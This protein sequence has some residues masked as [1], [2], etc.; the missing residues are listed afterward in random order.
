MFSYRLMRNAASSLYRNRAGGA[1]P[2]LCSYLV[3]S[4]CNL[5]C[6]GCSYRQSYLECGQRMDGRGD[7]DTNAALALLRDSGFSRMPALILA[8]GE[9]LM[10]ED[11]FVL[12]REA[13]SH[14]PVTI[15][16]TNG[17]LIDAAAAAGIDAGFRMC[18]VSLDG[19]RAANDI[20]RGPGS[21]DM[22]V[23]GITELLRKRKKAR[24]AVACV[25]NRHNVATLAGFAGEMRRLGVDSVKF[26][27]N[28]LEAL[29]PDPDR[30]AE[31][32]EPL[33]DF[34][35]KHPGFVLGGPDFLRRMI[36]YIGGKSATGCIAECAAHMVI[37]PTGA[38]SLC[39]YYP[40]AL[41]GVHCLKDLAGMSRTELKNKLAGCP[42]CL[43][44]DEF[45]ILS[46]LK[47][48]VSKIRWT[49]V[50]RNLKP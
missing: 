6:E 26:Q 35:R 40:S 13:A 22:A 49:R 41:P 11:L 30:A 43:R 3:T 34:S 8:G 7:L 24:V 17:T 46:L 5:C 44:Y 50:L 37:S 32:L 4:A 18:A 2:L 21:F 27:L 33:C 10:R 25:V 19:D 31:G 45:A 12:A 16:V 28:F 29:Q 39:C 48:P 42:G 14:V 47:D 9:P 20:I 1:V 23:N 36:Q 38:Y 15:L